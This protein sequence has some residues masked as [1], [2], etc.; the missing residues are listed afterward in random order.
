MTE[1]FIEAGPGRSDAY[2]IA[3]YLGE[4]AQELTAELVRANERIIW[5]TRIL[6]AYTVVLTAFTG[7]L[8]VLTVVTLTRR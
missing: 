1:S 3:N 8:V 4:R 2:K 7:V 5:L 6:V